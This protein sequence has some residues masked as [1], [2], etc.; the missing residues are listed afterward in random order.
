M[1]TLG[2]RKARL[3]HF[4]H[5][6]RARCWQQAHG[7]GNKHSTIEG[8]DVGGFAPRPGH[9][10]LLWQPRMPQGAP[11]GR[12][13]LFA[14]WLEGRKLSPLWV[15]LESAG[16]RRGR[17]ILLA[18]VGGLPCCLRWILRSRLVLFRFALGGLDAPQ[19]CTANPGVAWF[20]LALVPLQGEEARGVHLNLTS[21]LAPHWLLA[22]LSLI[23]LHGTRFNQ[24]EYAVSTFQGL[25]VLGECSWPSA[26]VRDFFQAL[27]R[28]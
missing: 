5:A 21:S 15:F 20:P 18:V 6:F 4:V 14:N 17:Q 11:R 23:V 1:S 10:G 2:H 19:Q 25:S 8:V 3:L 27:T 26:C 22:N 24:S 28:V 12:A 7:A 9:G 13:S 16:W